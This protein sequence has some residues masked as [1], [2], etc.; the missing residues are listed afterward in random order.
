MSR[1]K[2]HE[3]HANHERWL[4]SYADFITLLFA[5]FVV[6]F[7]NSQGDQNQKQVMRFSK[8]MEAA[9]N[10]FSVFDSPGSL[11]NTS[12]NNAGGTAGRPIVT[13]V[14]FPYFANPNLEKNDQIMSEGG[15][16]KNMAFGEPTAEE[17][18]F[19]R[20]QRDMRSLFERMDLTGSVGI[21]IDERGLIISLKEAGIFEK[22]ADTLSKTS[23]GILKEIGD[24]LIRMPD[25]EVRIEGHTDN[26]PTKGFKSNWDLSTM[27]ATYVVQWLLDHYALNP[28]RF[29]AVGFS[30]YNPVA[31]NATEEGR[32]RNRRV[33]VIV[34][35]KDTAK[36]FDPEHRAVSAT[37]QK[38]TP[39]HE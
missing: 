7:A 33:D 13:G 4:V 38:A 16:N 17:E 5:F 11:L 6:M 8:A 18:L 2:K 35:S 34:L 31:D 37:Q 9:F 10:R 28:K 21:Q 29:A 39:D 22:G 27:R 23:E 32:K 12:S 19:A 30:E 15:P 3:E 26:Q 36:R 14:A 25:H 20:A 1:K 24:V